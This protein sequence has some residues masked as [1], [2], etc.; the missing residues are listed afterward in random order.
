MCLLAVTACSH[1]TQPL[2][3]GEQADHIVILKSQHQMVLMTQG[4]LLRTY[5]VA[6][7]RASGNKERR[8]D[9]KTPLGH[10]VI[11]QKNAQS[12]F[13]LALHVSYPNAA[14]QQHAREAGVDPGDAILIHGVRKQFAWLGSLQHDIDWTDGCIAVT[15]DEMDEVWKLVPT[16]TPV[17]IE[18]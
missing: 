12:R 13:H 5:R 1:H 9:H 3:A 17:D 16:G 2:P 10:Y 18:P 8:G 6:L 11:D 14:D 7:G 4:K 15:N